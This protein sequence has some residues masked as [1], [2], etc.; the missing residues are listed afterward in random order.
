MTGWQG[1]NRVATGG[2]SNGSVCPTA[3]SLRHP[4]DPKAA[5]VPTEKAAPVP[6]V[7][8]TAPTPAPEAAPVPAAAPTPASEAA[9]APAAATTPTPM[10]CLA[11]CVAGPCVYSP[12]ITCVP[13]SGAP[14]ARGNRSRACTMQSSRQR[15]NASQSSFAS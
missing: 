12:L 1:C 8:A 13:C 15:Q 14:A 11:L 10:L 2:G 9:P 7:P 4:P 6:P 5:P 3:A